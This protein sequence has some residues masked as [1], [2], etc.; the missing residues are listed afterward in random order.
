[1]NK[2]LKT[3]LLV[4]AL[5]LGAANSAYAQVAAPD[6][7]A[8][9][10]APAA[11]PAAPATGGGGGGGN[12]Q[13]VNDAKAIE[14]LLL[15]VDG[16]KTVVTNQA[17]QIQKQTDQITKMDEQLAAMAKQLE[18]MT[19][20]KNMSAVGGTPGDD[21]DLIAAKSITELAKSAIGGAGVPGRIGAI[22]SQLKDR[23]DFKD[24][25]EMLASKD[26][27]FMMRGRTIAIGIATAA[28]A[29]D[30]YIRANEAME[31]L[32]KYV[33][34]I[35]KTPDLKASVDLNTRVLIELLQ[36]TN[37]SFRTNASVAALQSSFSLEMMSEMYGDM[38][39][40]DIKYGETDFLK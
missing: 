2:L 8:D 6:P 16:Q 23:F 14:Q 17:D 20:A 33:A 19:G 28:T 4:S 12:V 29:E 13:E 37:E 31:R 11:A 27:R 5:A 40:F 7:V 22:I 9:P 38:H 10:N 18:A 21:S 26:R 24:L 36:S 15:I 35:D 34:E 39:K 32:T 1:M 30:Q 3:T 25:P